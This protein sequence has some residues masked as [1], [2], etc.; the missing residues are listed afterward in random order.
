MDR[1]IYLTIV[2]VMTGVGQFSSPTRKFYVLIATSIF[3]V[4]KARLVNTLYEMAKCE[5]DAF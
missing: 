2:K 5:F 4:L 3:Y 1:I